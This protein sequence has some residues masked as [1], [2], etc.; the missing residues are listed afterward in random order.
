MVNISKNSFKS[1]IILCGGMSTRMGQDKGKMLLDE[2]PIILHILEQLNK[3]MNEVILVLRDDEQVEEYQNVIKLF[4]SAKSVLNKSEFKKTDKRNN[5]KDLNEKELESPIFAFKLK[6][7]T[8][9]IKNQGPLAG[10][11]TGLNHISSD[12]GLIIP[13]DS[14][15]ISDS[16]LENIFYILE[17]SE[18]VYD[19][20]VPQWD[21]QHIEPL[22]SIYHQRTK[23]LIEKLISKEI[24]SV[25]SLIEQ[26]NVFFIDVK[27]LD[28]SLKSFKNLNR[29]QDLDK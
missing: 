7:V 14:P 16:F 8:D 2:K 5:E 24:R 1:C 26:L 10:I 27:S 23:I 20:M 12:Y 17:N 13:C 15:Y 29:P 18:N 19:A 9:K 21:N 11:Y 28:P 4:K 22:H 6:L 3:Q 25:K